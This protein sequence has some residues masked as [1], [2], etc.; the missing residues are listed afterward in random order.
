M[1]LDYREISVSELFFD[2]ENPRIPTAVDASDDSL[3]LDWMLS[4]AS[5]LELM[6]S[7]GTK[8]FFPAEPLLVSPRPQGGY[9]VLEG[10]RRLAAVYLLLDP[11]RAPQRKQAVAAAAAGASD[12]ESLNTLPCAVFDSRDEVIDYLGYR[13]ITG[14][15]QWEPE[16]KAQYMEKLYQRHIDTQG[17]DVYRHI[18][19]LIGSRSDYVVRLLASLQYHLAIKGDKELQRILKHDTVPFSFVTLALTYRPVLDYLGVE[20]L[21]RDS[22]RSTPVDHLRDLAVWL[23]HEQPALDRTQLG[24][25]HNMRRLS[26]ALSYTSGVEALKDG[27]VVEEAAAAT[28]SVEDQIPVT[29][30][31]SRDQLL[32]AQRLTHRATMTSQ[33]IDLLAEILELADQMLFAARRKYRNDRSLDV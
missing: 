22:L 8:G 6:G 18:A 29:L 17:G 26:Q 7:I 2:P 12:I 32:S 21:S 27:A 23:F 14:V 19:R 9:Y 33:T 16:A 15:K 20:T 1:A 30:R 28:V 13:H 24:D 25:S 11:S 5:L 4:D 3:V 10:N 31:R